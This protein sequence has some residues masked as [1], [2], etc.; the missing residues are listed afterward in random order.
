[1]ALVRYT[2]ELVQ[3]GPAGGGEPVGISQAAL[4]QDAHRPPP[5]GPD[6]L[7]QAGISMHAE[8]HGG[9]FDRDRDQRGGRHRQIVAALADG[10]HTDPGGKPGH[11]PPV[12][13]LFFLADGF[14][15][16]HE[17]TSAGTGHRRW[18]PATSPAATRIRSLGW[19]PGR[20][21]RDAT[22]WRQR[23]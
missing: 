8:Q 20:L 2:P 6:R 10:D 4:G 3:G 16:R 15:S 1:S 14:R 9:W 17:T 19:S 13:V 22:T 18:P 7:G 21:P 5:P 11:H 23:P 12:V